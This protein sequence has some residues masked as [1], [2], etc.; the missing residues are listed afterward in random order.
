LIS[1]AKESPAF[2]TQQS[3]AWF[4]KSHPVAARVLRNT[5]AQVALLRP[6]DRSQAAREVVSEFLHMDEP[7]KL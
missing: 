5:L 2:L 6:D 4:Y 7:R 3:G 1:T